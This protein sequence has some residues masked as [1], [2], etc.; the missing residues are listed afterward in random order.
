[1]NETVAAALSEALGADVTEM[2]Q[3]AGGASKEA[4]AVTTADGRELI[5]RRAGGGVIH[6]SR[7]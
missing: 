1:M 3:L 6:P 2:T 4:W 5:V 7:V